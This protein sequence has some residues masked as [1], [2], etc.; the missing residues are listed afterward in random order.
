MRVILDA[1][2]FIS[3]LL[4]P[5]SASAIS[6]IVESAFTKRFVPLVTGRILD[7]LTR[8]VV[9]KPY[10]A[11]RIDMADVA[12]LTQ[13]LLEVAEIIPDIQEEVPAVSRDR[14][15]DYLLAYAL[16]G[17][18]DFLVTGDNDL[19]TLGEVE[20]CRIVSPTNFASHLRAVE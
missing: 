12:S 9:T 4:T 1:N 13:S 20:G 7:E 18:A 16:V 2:I 5:T 14:K 8:R 19:L 17:R 3:Y 11:Q 6:A 10:L 15:D